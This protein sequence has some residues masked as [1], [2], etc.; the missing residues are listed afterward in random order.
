MIA[1]AD[2]LVDAEALYAEGAA[3]VLIPAALAAEHLYR[4]LRD[5]SAEAL[6]SARAAQMRELFGREQA[7]PR[8][9]A[10]ASA[11]PAAG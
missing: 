7:A 8:P 10:A 4:L 1:T 2:R 6:E 11:P 5:S 9:P 3:Y